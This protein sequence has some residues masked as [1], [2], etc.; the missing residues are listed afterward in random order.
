M[1]PTP[2]IWGEVLQKNP[3]SLFSKDNIHRP[4]EL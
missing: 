3:Q 4:E 1:N 2:D